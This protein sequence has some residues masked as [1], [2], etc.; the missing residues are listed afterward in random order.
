MRK[1]TNLG[2]EYI[3]YYPQI[4]KKAPQNAGPLL[5]L[6]SIDYFKV[7]GQGLPALDLTL[8]IMKSP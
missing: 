1:K 8:T 7:V 5:N 3:R 2:T 4:K 6:I